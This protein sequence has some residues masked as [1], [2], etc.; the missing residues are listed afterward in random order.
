MFEISK[1][2]LAS[3]D[4]FPKSDVGMKARI[5]LMSGRRLLDDSE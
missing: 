1:S 4:N 2:P 5:A 3:F